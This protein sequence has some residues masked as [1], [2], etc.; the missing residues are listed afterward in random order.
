MEKFHASQQRVAGVKKTTYQ[1][2]MGIAEMNGKQY[3]W[4]FSSFVTVA[5]TDHSLSPAPFAPYLKFSILAAYTVADL[6]LKY[7]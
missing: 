1:A 3:K 5:L 6:R 7:I 4:F 2:L